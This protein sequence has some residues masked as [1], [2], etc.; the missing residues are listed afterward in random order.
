MIEDRLNK[1]QNF[2]EQE[3][4]QLFTQICRGLCYIHDMKIVHRDIKP[5]NIFVSDG[6]SQV[7]KIGDFGVSKQLSEWTRSF[8][9]FNGGTPGFMAPELNSGT[10]WTEKVDAW[11]LGVILFRLCYYNN[12]PFPQGPLT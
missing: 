9:S 3:I 8:K 10:S 5:A 2:Y 7:L 4:L 6:E 12:D 11:A 1:N